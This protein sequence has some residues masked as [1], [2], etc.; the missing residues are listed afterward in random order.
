MEGGQLSQEE[1]AVV[2]R[3][4]AEL[5]RTQDESDRLDTAAVEAAA[6]EAGLSRPAVCQ[7]LAELRVGAIEPS[8][9]AGQRVLL[10]PALLTVRRVVPGPL[11]AVKR[12]M[13]A[14]LSAQLFEQRRDFGERTVWTRREGLLPS[15]RRS[16]D[17]NHRLTLNGV[18]SLQLALAE[19]P[20]GAGRVLVSVEADVGEQRLAHVWLA[21]GGATVGVG[22]VGGSLL[23]D[24]VATIASLPISAGLVVGGHQL[25]RSYYRREVGKI[26]TALAG[27]L[28]RLEHRPRSP[29]TAPFR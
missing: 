1:I 23:I 6:V 2:L 13:W 16:L 21:A 5:D 22:V 15:V 12:E 10:G 17:L 28:D 20:D 9:G 25:G 7:A 14:Y 3:R 18:R 4:A 19:P 8:P 29:I 26:E 11:E 27:L 24:L